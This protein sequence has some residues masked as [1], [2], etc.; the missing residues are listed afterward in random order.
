MTS[1]YTTL[2]QKILSTG[3]LTEAE[4]LAFFQDIYEQTHK[5]LPDIVGKAFAEAEFPTKQYRGPGGLSNQPNG[6]RNS[7]PIG[8]CDHFTADVSLTGTLKWFSSK[9]WPQQQG[10]AKVAGASAAFVIDLDGTPYCLIDFWNGKA[11]WHE[12]Q[13]NGLCVGIEHVNAGELRRQLDG[14]FTMWQ[15]G[16]QKKYPL[17]AE[18]PPLRVPNGWRGASYMMPYTREQ[19][20]TNLVIKRAFCCAYEAVARPEMFVDHATYRDDK[21]D[22][23]PHWPLST[24]RNAAFSR[25]PLDKYVFLHAYTP[26]QHA[27]LDAIDQSDLD[28]IAQTQTTDLPLD[29]NDFPSQNAMLLWVQ[30]ALHELGYVVDQTG[31]PSKQT[32]DAVKRFQAVNNLTVD[33]VP[34]PKTREKLSAALKRI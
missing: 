17:D 34:G 9:E 5:K 24:L 16:W 6:W 33:G 25:E 27:K 13:L 7:T 4:A 19:V 30:L 8:I 18:L 20:I 23:G 1:V 11:D 15:N 12:P 21:K 26:I 10:P 22:M 2:R 3:T 32:T 28:L 29:L 31:K 14:T